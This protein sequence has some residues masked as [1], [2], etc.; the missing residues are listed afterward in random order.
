[1]RCMKSWTVNKMSLISN[2]NKARWFGGP[3]RDPGEN[4]AAKQLAKKGYKIVYRNYDVGF[5]EID[6]VAE[7][8]GIIAFVEVKQRKTAAFGLPCQAVG[9]EKQRKIRRA[10]EHYLMKNKTEKQPR[11]DVMEIYGVCDG[12]EKPR[13]RHIENAF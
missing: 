12:M 13:A 7:K 6:L 1:M 10:A 11:F 4:F 2:F 3:S 5:A 9:T 8:K